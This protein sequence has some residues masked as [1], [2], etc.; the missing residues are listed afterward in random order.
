MCLAAI[1]AFLLVMSA[2]LDRVESFKASYQSTVI[3]AKTRELTQT[4]DDAKE[5]IRQ[6]Q[7]LAVVTAET[8]IDLKFNSHALVVDDVDIAKE[9]DEFE[10]TVIASLRK[11]GLPEDKLDQVSKS[12]RNV[13]VNFYAYAAYRF[14]RDNLPQDKW[15]D[16]DAAYNKI[17]ASTKAISPDQ[18][19]SYGIDSGKFSDYMAD[20]RYYAEQGQQ[21]RPVVWAQRQAWGFGGVPH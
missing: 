10:A 6:I 14:G 15:A 12:D 7:E 19:K 16:F 18:A 3:E 8:L 5:A 13:V 17:K 21:R 11:M 2:N 20:Y 1:P 9:E 4:I